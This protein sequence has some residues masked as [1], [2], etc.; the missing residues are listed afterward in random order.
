MRARL[1]AWAIFTGCLI[2]APTSV[3]AIDTYLKGSVEVEGQYFFEAGSEQ[4]QKQENAS[5][6]GQ[7]AF[8]LF[9]DDGVHHLAFEPF[10][11]VDWRDS[12]RSHFD[13][14]QAKY[15]LAIDG[16]DLII[17]VDKVYWGVM[18]AVHLVDVI[19]QTD[20]VESMDGEE[21]LGQPMVRLS[22]ESGWGTFTAFALPYFRERTFAG[23]GGR[24]RPDF[25]IDDSRTT[26]ESG[27]EKEHFDWAIRYQAYLGDF[28]IGLA[29][30]QGTAREPEFTPLI[31]R[32]GEEFTSLACPPSTSGQGIDVVATV[33]DCLLLVGQTLG[34]PLG[35]IGD[36]RVE[37]APHYSLMEQTSIDVQ[38]VLGSWLVKAEA[39]SRYQQSDRF[40]QA[41][42]GVEYSFYGI[43]NTGADLGV[44]AEYV[45]DERGKAGLN[46]FQNDIFVGGRWALN[47]VSS[48]AI[49][50]GG[51]VDLETGAALLSLEAEQRLGG[52]FKVSV[53]ARG[54]IDI[55]DDDPLFMI[56]DDSFAQL[57][58]AWYF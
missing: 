38:A 40:M 45:W 17:G 28:E 24:P 12:D 5:L 25:R 53:E 2:Y 49:L 43:F 20:T 26:Y 9:S 8:D 16:F 10:G 1:G 42:A 44:I 31:Y 52:A 55:P 58:L 37:L 27:R 15:Q 41:T 6:S 3:L 39:L 46:S 4:D 34:L 35:E 51:A 13:L 30:F 47:N 18:E 48:T 36:I 33:N 23:T 7:L 56:S 11:R 54:F 22:Y 32:N 57:R 14:R 29:H 21:K 19:N 50:A